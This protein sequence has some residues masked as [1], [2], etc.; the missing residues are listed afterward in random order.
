[1]QSTDE[2]LLDEQLKSLTSTEQQFDSCPVSYFS[3][4]SKNNLC[5]QVGDAIQGLPSLISCGEDLLNS[6]DTDSDQ[7]SDGS[8]E[9]G[10]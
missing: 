6:N 10:Y 7:C 2:V 3:L 1:M 5:N 8:N 9:G 4:T